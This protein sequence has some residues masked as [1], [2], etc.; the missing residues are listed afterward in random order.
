[1]YLRRRDRGRYGRLDQRDER[2]PV[3]R[4]LLFPIIRK[5]KAKRSADDG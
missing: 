3:L 2:T 4:P 1:M 5:E